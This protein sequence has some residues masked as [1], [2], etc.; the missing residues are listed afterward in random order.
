[1]FF[2]ITYQ[3]A[4]ATVSDI[5]F[6]RQFSIKNRLTVPFMAIIQRPSGLRRWPDRLSEVVRRASFRIG[7]A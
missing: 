6:A 3:T 1:M 7:P 2:L 4:Q 5:N